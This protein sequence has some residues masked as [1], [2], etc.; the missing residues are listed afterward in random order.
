MH[1]AAIILNGLTGWTYLLAGSVLLAAAAV[2][3]AQQDLERARVLGAGADAQV[4]YRRGILDECGTRL[5]ALAE[6][7]DALLASLAQTHLNLAP[8]GS[9]PLSLPLP[10][11]R[12]VLASEHRRAE[13]G[14]SFL[15]RLVTRRPARP[16]VVVLAAVC[17]LV[18]LLPPASA[19]P[20]RP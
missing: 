20:P 11:A 2:I 15:A 1:R 14:T 18:G 19:R 16:L 3:P 9:R 6:P 12:A 8:A 10:P 4:E 13:P 17:V 5:A 7:S